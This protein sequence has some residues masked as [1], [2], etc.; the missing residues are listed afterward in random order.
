MS[1]PAHRIVLP[2]VLVIKAPRRF[3]RDNETHSVANSDGCV[4][5]YRAR[6]QDSGF[7]TAPGFRQNH[8]DNR[9]VANEATDAVRRLLAIAPDPD[10]GELAPLAAA[11]ADE[12]CVPPEGA[13]L[14]LTM[15]MTRSRQVRRSR[16]RGSRGRGVR[17]RSSS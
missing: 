16:S 17:R 11:G 7:R 14:A 8:P 9:M 2:E 15:T 13:T 6:T 3:L 5:R 10:S 4:V 1:R 12:D